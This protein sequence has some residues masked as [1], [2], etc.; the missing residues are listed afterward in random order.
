MLS[1]ICLL[2][3]ENRN[4]KRGSTQLDLLF[5]LSVLH[6]LTRARRRWPVRSSGLG[7][8]G[9]FQCVTSTYIRAESHSPRNKKKIGERGLGLSLFSRCLS[10]SP[11]WRLCLQHL[12]HGPVTVVGADRLGADERSGHTG[13]RAPGQ[14]MK[15]KKATKTADFRQIYCTRSHTRAK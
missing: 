13:R 9:R 10:A 7:A 14:E 3:N 5:L 6:M 15:E 8:D 4:M 1:S 2:R 12:Q 11:K